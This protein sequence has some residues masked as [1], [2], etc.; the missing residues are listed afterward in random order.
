[1]H[2]DSA[3]TLR[4]RIGDHW[5]GAGDDDRWA[6]AR[7]MRALPIIIMTS[8]ACI[9]QGQSSNA[10]ARQPAATS[11]KTLSER[12]YVLEAALRYMMNAHSSQGEE[13]DHY[14][15]YVLPKDGEF[16]PELVAAF[17]GYKPPVMPRTKA[18]AGN[19][20]AH[21]EATGKPFKF[22]SGKVTDIH[23]DRAT[24]YVSWYV[25]PL[26]AGGHTLQLRRKEGKWI[27][28]SEKQDW[29]S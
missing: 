5:R 2:T 15:A 1:M 19:R 3:M 7:I 9:A 10:P 25:G 6:A 24:A 26:A 4:F 13:R 22:W 28:E 20:G 16:T 18:A 23:R 21:D 11:P 27:V 14:F 12:Y 17:A 29:I 8:L